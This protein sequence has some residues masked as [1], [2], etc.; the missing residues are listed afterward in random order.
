[1]RPHNTADKYVVMLVASLAMTTSYKTK[2]LEAC[3]LHRIEL[4]STTAA[5]STGKKRP[6]DDGKRARTNPLSAKR[7]GPIVPLR[8]TVALGPKSSPER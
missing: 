5:Q 8:L 6:I 4:D 7:Y 2:I 3:I 1:M